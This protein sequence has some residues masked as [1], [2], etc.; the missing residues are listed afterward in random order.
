MEPSREKEPTL[1]ENWIERVIRV[2]SRLKETTNTEKR[3]LPILYDGLDSASCTTD[4]KC[5][6]WRKT[7]FKTKRSGSE[8]GEN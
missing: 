6:S 7:Q 3:E 2:D 4:Y 5:D 8:E 1:Y